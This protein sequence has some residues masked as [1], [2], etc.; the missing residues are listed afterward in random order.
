MQT[1][2][3]DPALFTCGLPVLGICYGVQLI[4]KHFGGQ[5]AKKQA[6]EDGQ[7]TI[8]VETSKDSSQ[9]KATPPLED[10]GG[11]LIIH[12]HWGNYP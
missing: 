12:T 3:Y 4:V 5:V 11:G 8:D 9:N 2:S 1:L 6:R 10:S 7:F